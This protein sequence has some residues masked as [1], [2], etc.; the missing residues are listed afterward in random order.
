MEASNRPRFLT[1]PQLEKAARE[2]C[3]LTN[4]E[5]DEVVSSE[6]K[7]RKRWQVI[8]AQIRTHDALDVLIKEARKDDKP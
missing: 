5:P 1:R 7:T 4:L 3:A 2:Y 6:G 8:A